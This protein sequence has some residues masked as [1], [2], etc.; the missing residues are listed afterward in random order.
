[1]T[2]DSML[3]LGISALVLSSFWMLF[4]LVVRRPVSRW[5][6]A[7]WAYYLWLVPLVGLLAIAS[8]VK[9]ARQQFGFPDIGIP[10]I[11]LVIDGTVTAIANFDTTGTHKTSGTTIGSSFITAKNLLILWLIGS[12]AV[13]LMLAVRSIRFATRMRSASRP[14]S[15]EE[16][17]QIG[18]RCTALAGSATTSV[19]INAS[20]SGP[21]VT[22]M[23]RPLL[24]LPR[25]FFS[26]Y[27]HDQQILILQ[28]EQQHLR[29]HDLLW[30][31]LAR[32]YR[33]LFWFNPLVYLAERYLQLDQELSCDEKVLAGQSSET[34]RVYG[35]T[36]LLSAHPHEPLPQVG[37][38]PSFR[39]I[40]E[41]TTMLKHHN[42]R[43]ASHFFGAVLVVAVSIV[44]S[45]T[46]GVGDSSED[47]QATVKI[48]PELYT[49]VM[50]IQSHI[51]SDKADDST[52][53]TALEAVKQLKSD[54][55]DAGLTDYE[56]AQLSNLAGY[57]NFLRSN[58]P[59]AIVSYERVVK[60]TNE[61]PALQAATLKT[62]AQLY[63]TTGDYE[64]ALVN[65]KQ[66]EKVIPGGPTADVRMLIGQAYFQL[67]QYDSALPYFDLAVE[68][69]E[70][71]GQVPKENWLV[72][73]KVSL[74]ELGELERMEAVLKKLIKLYPK[75][76]YE[77]LLEGAQA[78]I[79]Q[80]AS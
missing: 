66:L 19:R 22:G 37:Y 6:G 34:R 1:M 25:D 69:I 13:V 68:Q 79:H 53:A 21:A 31:Y 76:E 70:S 65:L 27:S 54:Y 60:L 29:R 80:G 71:Q 26:R 12:L 8:P 45:V 5:L 16:Q 47:R 77:R 74:G 61:A 62:I 44:A 78:E 39:Q 35:E 56:L 7:R 24:L 49:R 57:T 64:Q 4:V 46:Y 52:Y 42:H 73:Q 75:P 38:L 33:C 11:N 59:N 67:K 51:V 63:F 2:T 72:L 43:L 40:K 48:R 41:R 14:L 55:K 28:H 30:L 9:S 36:L 58:Y 50:E 23:F 32:I 17:S 15:V 3:E 10:G 20:D 18:A